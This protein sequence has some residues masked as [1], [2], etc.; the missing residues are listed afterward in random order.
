MLSKRPPVYVSGGAV[1]PYSDALLRAATA[2]SRFGESYELYRVADDGSIWLPRNLCPAS[3]DDRRTDGEETRYACT[4]TAR[5]VEQARIVEDATALLR[6]GE[7]FIVQAPTGW[8]KTIVGCAIAGRI[9]RKTLVITTKEDI[10]DQWLAAAR[11]VLGLDPAEIDIWRGDNVPAVDAKLVLA[12]V[13]SILKGPERYPDV[14]FSSF[15][16]VICDEVHRMAADQFSQAMWWFPGKLRLGL[17]ATPYRRDGKEQVFLG[18]IGPVLL[19]ARHETMIPRIIVR[20]SEWKVPMVNRKT[21]TGWRRVKL[22]HEVG[23]TM[24]LVKELARCRSRTAMIVRFL[25]TA[26]ARKRNTMVFSD[27]IE[28]LNVIRAALLEAGIP[29]AV[30]GYYVGASQSN[31]IYEGGVQERKRQRERDKAKPILLATYAMASEATDI[32][33]MDT[34]VLAS[35][36]SDVVQIVGRIRREYPDKP[37]PVV[38][39]IV[40]ADSPVFAMYAQKRLRWYKS[41]GCEIRLRSM[42]GD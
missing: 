36:R 40:D 13:Q 1:Y 4:F 7:N 2:E 29:D 35:P 10:L 17:S 20:T 22:P 34:A 15:G 25:T 41:L 9:K 8:G 30:I 37:M 12:L 3:E 24:H 19:T 23:K 26:L 14:D 21:Q 11:S 6:K 18:H 5:S 32:P 31:G 16:L 33:W 38:L 42:A 39:D 27:T 28:H